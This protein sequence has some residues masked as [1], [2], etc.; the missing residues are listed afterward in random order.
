M[1]K[2]DVARIAESCIMKFAFADLN[3]AIRAREF[4]MGNAESR[5]EVHRALERFDVERVPPRSRVHGTDAALVVEPA[6]TQDEAWAE[7]GHGPGELSRPRND[8]DTSRPAREGA[9]AR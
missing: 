9:S 7:E 5:S 4:L 1:T 3:V 6:G 2:D 8:G